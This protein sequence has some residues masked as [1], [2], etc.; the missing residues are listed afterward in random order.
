[1]R[2][3]PQPQDSQRYFDVHAWAAR[4]C[5]DGDYKFREILLTQHFSEALPFMGYDPK[6]LEAGFDSQLD[7]YEYVASSPFFNRDIFLLENRNAKS[8]VRDKKRAMYMQFL[9]WCEA[10]TDLPAYQYPDDKAYWLP[11]IEEFF[12]HFKAEYAQAVADLEELRAVKA[13]FNGEWVAKLTGLQGKELGGLMKRFKE[14][15]ETPAA[16]NSF[17]LSSSSDAIEA[18]VRDAQ[19]AMTP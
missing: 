10:R 1:M 13:K 19:A 9:R 14:S 18:R 7:I 11:R 4:G 16:M 8:R 17:L 2:R 3:K 6:V 5:R 12:P 15:F